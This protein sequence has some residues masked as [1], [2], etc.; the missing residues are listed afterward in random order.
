MRDV[1]RTVGFVFILT[2]VVT[3]I[4]SGLHIATRGRV[5]ENDRLRYERAVLEA[6]GIIGAPRSEVSR[7]YG[8][9]E[10]TRVGFEAGPEQV[11]APNGILY[12]TLADGRPVVAMPFTGPGVWGDI[13]GVIS[14]TED[15]ETIVGLSILDHN[16][17]PG[18]GGR[19][20][21]EEFLAQFRGERISA[22]GIAL[23]RGR[24]D[25]DATNASVDAISGA[26]GSSRA[27]HGIVNRTIA[28]LQAILAD[29]Q[30]S[31]LR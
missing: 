1:G 16:E 25:T 22:D 23:S 11:F 8:E 12:R 19:I 28:A 20:T 15:L 4:L 29:R 7:T 13:V 18:L 14:V 26:T 31:M 27:L 6:V 17:T 10:R 9:L 5:A 21:E 2:F 30:V 3:G 24:G